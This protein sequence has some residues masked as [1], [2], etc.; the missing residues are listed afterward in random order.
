[1]FIIGND[2]HL[3]CTAKKNSLENI[4]RPLHKS[5]IN[6][7]KNIP[8]SSAVRFTVLAKVPTIQT[9]YDCASQKCGPDGIP[10]DEQ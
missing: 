1:M 6:Q 7:C 8:Q 4:F 10:R 5:D 9:F 2:K 3:S